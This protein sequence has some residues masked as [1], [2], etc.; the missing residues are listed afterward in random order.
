M[1]HRPSGAEILSAQNVER[2]VRLQAA[3]RIV[4]NNEKRL[5]VLQHAVN[6][7]LAVGAQVAFLVAP[8]L[9]VYVSA[10][11][12]L[13]LFVSRLLL[14][15]WAE[16]L[17]GRGAA[18]H[19]DFDR[20]VLGIEPGPDFD[21]RRLSDEEVFAITSTVEL[22]P[23]RNWYNLPPKTAWPASVLL[24]LRSSAVWARRQHTIFAWILGAFTLLVFAEGIVV[25]LMAGT[26]L[27]TYLLVIALPMLPLLLDFAELTRLHHVAAVSRRRAEREINEL[28]INGG[29][30]DDM[31]A[32]IQSQ[33]SELR[34]S[35]PQIPQ[36][37]YRV[38]RT[39]YERDTEY[40]NRGD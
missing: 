5:R 9:G 20:H 6:I 21:R 38:V 23:Y 32:A 37:L 11:A 13:W 7:A 34:R 36:T 18:C 28:R 24:C 25:G 30:T 12:G 33:L 26:T 31:L 39:G 40:A 16:V 35:S 22:D 17:R 4:R 19:D 2:N 14:D 1:S 15:R 29:V 27:S 3:G 8:W 10:A